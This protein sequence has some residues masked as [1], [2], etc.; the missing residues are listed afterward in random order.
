MNITFDPDVVPEPEPETFHQNPTPPDTSLVPFDPQP[1]A[2]H[3]HQRFAQ[4]VFLIQAEVD[5]MGII[6]E[7]TAADRATEI[8]A[9]CKRKLKELKAIKEETERPHRDYLRQLGNIFKQFQDPLE[10]FPRVL[11]QKLADFRRFQE[12]ERR[13]KIAAQ[14]AE[15]RRLRE[16]EEKKAQEAAEKG[17][18]YEPVA[19]APVVVE[20]PPKVTRTAEGSSSQ[21]KDWTFEITDPEKVPNE[22]RVI[23]EKMIRKAVKAGIREIPGVRIYQDYVTQFRT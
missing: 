8:G 4:E 23:D 10:H 22:Y 16:A 17:A 5:N 19:P 1:V 12:N 7:Q 6:T 9:V 2:A 15:A 11:G 21:R 18:P 14:E 3:V 20:E 13:R